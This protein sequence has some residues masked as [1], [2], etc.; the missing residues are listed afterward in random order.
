[1]SE[2]NIIKSITTHT[3]PHCKGEIFIESQITPPVIA[4]LFTSEDIEKAK[5]DC[6]ARVETL[7]MDEEK[8]ASVVK[9]LNDPNT[10]FGP[11]EVES[12]ILSLLK[13]EDDK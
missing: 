13:P 6:L 9:W 1:M 5:H 2:N 7:I 8:R 12:I 3:C 11:G 10:V 4:S